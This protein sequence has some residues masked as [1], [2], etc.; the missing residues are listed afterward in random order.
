MFVIG[1]GAEIQNSCILDGPVV[2][3]KNIGYN[4]LNVAR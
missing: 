4:S 2:K 1:M 3:I